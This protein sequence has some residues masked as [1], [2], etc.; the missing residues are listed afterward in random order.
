MSQT[1][2]I[3]IKG[4]VQGVGFRPFVYNLAKKID[5]KG[6]VFNNEDGVI[7]YCEST[8]E[9]A[10]NFLN[11]ILN[12]H[13]DIAV[14][15]SHNMV[16]T[17][18]LGFDDFSI[19]PS[20]KSTQLNLPLTPDFAI[21]NS[22]KKEIHSTENRRY[23]YAFTTC[24]NCG[25]R[26]AITRNYPF[27]RANTSLVAFKMC[28][29]CVDEY[30]NP[31]DRRFHSQ[32]NSCKSCGVKLKLV[33]N[34]TEIIST[35]QKHSITQA[36]DFIKNGNILAIKNT[37]GY[38][39]CSD[40]SNPQAIENLRKR[41]QRPQKPFAVMYPDFEAV[42]NDFNCSDS[43]KEAL[44]SGVAPIVILKN[45]K[46]TSIA[47]EAIAPNLQQTGVMLPSSALLE[48]LMAEMKLPIVA[49]SGNIH[50]SPILSIQDEAQEKLANV[51]DYFL[52]HN[53]D[54][55]FPQDDS[56]L[57]FSDKKKIILRRS[58]GLAPNYINT[59][60][61]TDTT[62]LA[63]GADLKS[64]IT[65]VPNSQTYVSQYFGNLENYEV[66]Q[67]YKTTISQY[68]KMF[69]AYPQTILVDKHSVYQ[70]TILGHELAT[71]W[72]ST[73]QE[74]QHHKAHF[75]SV[76]GEHELFLSNEKIL[77]VVWDGTG[78]GDDNQIWGGEFFTYQNHTI[79]RL[80]H[81][82]YFDWLVNDKMAKE[83]RIALF[84]LLNN[85]HRND[86]KHKFSNTEWSI[87]TKML[88]S[89]TLKTSSVGRLFDAVAS[90]LDITDKNTYEAEASMR[91]ENCAG[92][93]KGSDYID[94]LDGKAYK[95]IPSHFLVN[96]IVKALKE[97]VEKER[98]ACSFM[99][100]LAKSIIKI[101]NEKTFKTVACSGG[102]FQNEILTSLLFQLAN[103]DGIDIKLNRK[104]SPNDENLSFGQL[105]Y[106]QNIKN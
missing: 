95:K 31:A 11:Q 20:E 82:E 71:E 59:K 79:N 53:L 68:V 70:S 56:V 84:C 8:E 14:I 99:F 23:Y 64:T 89:N 63:M 18:G 98:L 19:V 48:L 6:S 26:Y 34:S 60:T 10:E 80:T 93:Y 94:F 47:V 28:D 5:L 57:R 76:L 43:E 88:Q 85:K 78:L 30:T 61:K 75:A 24:V 9:K 17:S 100:T 81:I 69:E 1:Y 103:K 83:P 41:K 106:K 77:G 97:G 44:Q 21:C 104:L 96:S 32:T 74:I 33:S 67:R 92:N 46:K 27:E 50:G 72:K 51:A 58:R 55:N 29:V 105:M 101:A 7:I 73:V 16:K 39:L 36:V 91:L 38:L 3:Q 62:V 37:S 65:F 22:C 13:P 15:T 49:T 52:H 42:Q 90:A 102:V 87:Y 4:Q 35:D 66:L 2:K 40:A 86:Y 54:I 25:P 12:N 45:S